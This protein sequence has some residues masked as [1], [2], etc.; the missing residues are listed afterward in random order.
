M[1]IRIDSRIPVVNDGLIPNA[2]TM[3]SINEAVDDLNDRK[4]KGASSYDE[5]EKL[6][7]K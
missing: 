6:L 5:L 2:K 7:D 1:D 3:S 4:L